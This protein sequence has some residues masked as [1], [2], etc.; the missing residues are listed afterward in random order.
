MNV[1]IFQTGE[2]LHSDNGNPRPMRAMNLANTLVTKGHNVVI[3]SSGFYHQK[4]IQ[5]AKL[6][7]KIFISK[8]LEIRLIPS[9]GYKKNISIQRLFDHFKLAYNLKK[10]LDVEK[11]LPDVAFVGY[12]PIET[13]FIMTNWLKKKKF[14]IY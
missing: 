1:W 13:A 2:P 12:P 7:K 9:P 14:H 5:R 3:W 6:Y 4:K 10:K 11:N 8:K